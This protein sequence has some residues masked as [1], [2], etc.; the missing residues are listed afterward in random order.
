MS[1]SRAR[2]QSIIR[3]NAH[4]F[5]SAGRLNKEGAEDLIIQLSTLRQDLDEERNKTAV[6]QSEVELLREAHG[7][8]VT[9]LTN[10]ISSKMD[11]CHARVMSEIEKE[12]QA[13][14]AKLP[15]TAVQQAPSA[16][17]R[18]PANPIFV[19]RN[20]TAAHFGD[21]NSQNMA[22]Y[23]KAMA[24]A[25]RLFRCTNIYQVLDTLSRIVYNDGSVPVFEGISICVGTND[26]SQGQ[27]SEWFMNRVSEV[28]AKCLELFPNA[29][30]FIFPPPPRTDDVAHS[31]KVDLIREALLAEY[32]RADDG[33]KAVLVPGFSPARFK[34]NDFL[35]SDG[36]HLSDG[37]LLHFAEALNNVLESVVKP[38]SF[39]DRLERLKQPAP[40]RRGVGPAPFRGGVV[41]GGPPRGVGFFRRG[42]DFYRGGGGA[43]ARRPVWGGRSGT[44]RGAGNRDEYGF[45]GGWGRGDYFRGRW[46]RGGYFPSVETPALAADTYVGGYF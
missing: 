15:K 1:D 31:Q 12:I 18:M 17:P 33:F 20:A 24:G 44:W 45:R 19:A 37:A 32:G 4:F 7:Q 5:D 27:D 22:H 46:G 2:R 29:K 3:N 35:R 11:E 16:A 40:Q 9:T 25:P 39:Q 30:C 34:E 21:S 42:A 23:L 10:T 36:I 13:A 41:R 8:L 14:F 43:P 26:V 28:R 38:L 6:L